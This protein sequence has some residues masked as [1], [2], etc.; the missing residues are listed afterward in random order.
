MKSTTVKRTE[1]G[2]AI[3]HPLFVKDSSGKIWRYD[4]MTVTG[5]ASY[6]NRFGRVVVVANH[7]D[8]GVEISENEL[9]S[10]DGENKF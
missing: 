6:K 4:A 2:K 8:L 9:N 7:Q 3:N 10:P 5:G 1:N